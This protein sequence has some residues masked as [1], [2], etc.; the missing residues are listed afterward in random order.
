MKSLLIPQFAAVQGSVRLPGSKSIANR[1]L[2]LSALTRQ[3]TQIQNLP[4]ADDILV[5][6]RNLLDLSF[7]IED[8]QAKRLDFNQVQQAVTRRQDLWLNG[9]PDRFDCQRSMTLQLDNAGTA[10][11]PLVAVLATRRGSYIIDGNEQMRRRPIQDL[12][13]ALQ[14]LGCQIEATAGCPPVRLEA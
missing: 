1:V 13:T 11:R 14:R 10:L 12:V 8:D 2:L 6:L 4:L 3:R 5:L 7:P 9:D